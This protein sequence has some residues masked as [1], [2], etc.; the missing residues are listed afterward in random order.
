VRLEG[1]GGAGFYRLFD[2][3]LCSVEANQGW[4]SRAARFARPL[5]EAKCLVFGFLRQ[6]TIDRRLLFSFSPKKLKKP[7]DILYHLLYNNTRSA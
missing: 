4:R 5:F 1:I 7:V 6:L 3:Y 2:R